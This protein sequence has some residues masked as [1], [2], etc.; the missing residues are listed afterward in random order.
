MLTSTSLRGVMAALVTPFSKDGSLVD[1]QAL[2]RVTERCLDAGIT[3]VLA[4]GTAGE[5]TTLRGS[6]RVQVVERLAS[7]ISGRVPLVVGTGTACT[8][9]SIENSLAAQAAGADAVMVIMPYYSRT[10]QDGLIAHVRAIHDALKLPIIVYNNPSRSIKLEPCTLE[11][12]CE[13]APRVVAIKD[14]SCDILECQELRRRL[15]DRLTI[16]CGADDLFV[17]SFAAGAEALTSILANVV[18][19]RIAELVRLARVGD[20]DAALRAQ[21]QILPLVDLIHAEPFPT[22]SKTALELLGLAHSTVRLPLM[23]SSSALREALRRELNR[24][25][26]L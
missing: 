13:Q 15:G 6:E 19:H 3:G 17:A 12:I 5:N 2:E 14:S 24:L 11:R 26:L 8:R 16:I 25:G 9:T 7:S 18:P 22:T 4:C 10:T 20:R 1:L 21:L 23:P